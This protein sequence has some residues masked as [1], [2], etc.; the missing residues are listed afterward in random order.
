MERS[1]LHVHGRGDYQD[2]APAA[3]PAGTAGVN[4][5]EPGVLADAARG[6]PRSLVVRAVY[7]TVVAATAAE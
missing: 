2:P 6:K 7:C 5:R 4:V 1:R 3:R